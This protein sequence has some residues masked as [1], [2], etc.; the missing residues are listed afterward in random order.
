VDALL[1]GGTVH[2][3]YEY[4]RAD[5]AHELRHAAVSLGPA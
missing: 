4:T 2:Y 5:R 1:V 3:F